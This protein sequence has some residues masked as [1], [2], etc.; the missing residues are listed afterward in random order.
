ML[1][2]EQQCCSFF[3][4]LGEAGSESLGQSSYL[5]NTATL[6]ARH[7]PL[8]GL[9]SKDMCWRALHCSVHYCREGSRTM[10]TVGDLC[11]PQGSLLIVSKR[12]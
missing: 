5:T 8:A 9:Y 11:E 12:L 4:S 10:Y 2:L 1:V 6:I 7:S 3:S